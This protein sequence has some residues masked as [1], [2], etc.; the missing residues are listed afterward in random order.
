MLD[1]NSFDFEKVATSAGWV[2]ELER[3]DNEHEE[4]ETFRRQSYFRT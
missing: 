3:E 1:T 4:M 2:Q